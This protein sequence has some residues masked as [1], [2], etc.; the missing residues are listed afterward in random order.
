MNGDQH[1]FPQIEMRK[2][3]DDHFLAVGYLNIDE[4][5]WRVVECRRIKLEQYSKLLGTES[6]MTQLKSLLTIKLYI[7]FG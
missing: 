4:I 1:A 3:G 2:H 7:L 6:K 5:R